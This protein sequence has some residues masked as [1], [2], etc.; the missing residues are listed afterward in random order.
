MKKILTILLSACLCIGLCT[1]C[2]GKKD[3]EPVSS[4]N[5][6][7]A[8]AY[9]AIES[10]L[11]EI[12]AVD[13]KTG[14]ETYCASSEDLTIRTLGV[15]FIIDQKKILVSCQY[16]DSNWVVESIIDRDKKI[17]YYLQGDIKE[18][19]DIYD[20]QSGTLIAPKTKD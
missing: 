10:V 11:E 20:F 4:A 6:A 5:Q 1:G 9:S 18:M 3:F 14:I 16:S 7:Y 2:F 8:E 17:H 12:G 19:F 13:E 15:R